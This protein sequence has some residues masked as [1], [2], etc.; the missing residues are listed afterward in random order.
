LGTFSLICTVCFVSRGAAEAS[1]T[2]TFDF[3]DPPAMAHRVSNPDWATNLA[4]RTMEDLAANYGNN[5]G[6]GNRLN[7]A[8]GA[9][10]E[11]LGRGR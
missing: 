4:L 5:L 11:A 1:D 2:T 9:G 8:M 3:D 10:E 6:S 7:M